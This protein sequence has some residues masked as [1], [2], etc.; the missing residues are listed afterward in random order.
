[1]FCLWIDWLERTIK[2]II[3]FK[4]SGKTFTMIGDKDMKSPGLYLLAAHDIFNTLKN[5]TK[6]IR[7]KI[8]FK[9]LIPNDLN[10]CIIL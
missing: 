6:K 7:F 3:I 5:V 2:I 8:F 4:G 10:S 1:M 9:E